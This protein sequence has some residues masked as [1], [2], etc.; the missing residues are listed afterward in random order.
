LEE[1]KVN[2]I[3]L[4]VIVLIGD[5]VRSAYGVRDDGFEVFLIFTKHNYIIIFEVANPMKN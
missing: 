2:A 4:S 1:K 3:R 5:Q